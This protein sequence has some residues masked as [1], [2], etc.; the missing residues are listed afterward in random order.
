MYLLKMYMNRLLHGDNGIVKVLDI[1][2]TSIETNLNMTY[3]YIKLDMV[4]LA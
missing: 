2:N 3:I 4:N 1:L